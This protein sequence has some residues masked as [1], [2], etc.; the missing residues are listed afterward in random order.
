MCSSD[1]LDTDVWEL[2]DLCRN[3][4]DGSDTRCDINS[5]EC[6]DPPSN[7]GGEMIGDLKYLPCRSYCNENC[8]WYW[9]GTDWIKEQPCVNDGCD[10]AKPTPLAPGTAN[11][12]TSFTACY[13]GATPSPTNCTSS[14]VYVWDVGYEEWVISTDCKDLTNCYCPEPSSQAPVSP[15]DTRATNCKPKGNT[16]DRKSTRLNSSH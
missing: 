3:R 4:T 5:C 14:C 7:E 15:T 9:D 1:L 2:T 10:C 8:T 16:K 12:P 11:G 13:T 6:P